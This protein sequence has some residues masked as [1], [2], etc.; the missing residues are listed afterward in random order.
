MFFK[1]FFLTEACV[2]SKTFEM[3]IIS[4]KSRPSSTP[5]L[6]VQYFM[7]LPRLEQ[8]FVMK[9]HHETSKQKHLGPDL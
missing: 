6:I 4:F 2:E 8:T 5:D 3:L 9:L 7:Y 1:I